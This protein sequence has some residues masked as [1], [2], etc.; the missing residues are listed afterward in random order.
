MPK[1]VQ[2]LTQ[3][4]VRNVKAKEKPYKPSRRS[5]ATAKRWTAWQKMG[6]HLDA[7]ILLC[8]QSTP[9]VW[10]LSCSGLKA[11]RCRASDHVLD[12]AQ[13]YGRRTLARRR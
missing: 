4:K 7:L 1:Q 12:V 2:L 13:G 3:P 9:A 8:R 11:R 10:A 5:A 6:G